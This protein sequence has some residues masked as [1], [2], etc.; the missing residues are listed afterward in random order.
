MLYYAYVANSVMLALL[1]VAVFQYLDAR[2]IQRK[3][4][5]FLAKQSAKTESDN[6]C[7]DHSD[8]MQNEP[9]LTATNSEKPAPTYIKNYSALLK[10]KNHQA[11]QYGQQHLFFALLNRSTSLKGVAPACGLLFTVISIMLSFGEF[12]S[13]GSVQKM[14]GIA[15]T[16]FSTTALGALVVVLCRLTIDRHIVPAMMMFD[17]Q[18]MRHRRQI[19]SSQIKS[20]QI[21]RRGQQRRRLIARS[22]QSPC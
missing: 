6:I 14:F 13:S 2:D 1:A 4:Y 22:G 21:R 15:A 5:K 8:A 9:A 16:G 18:L 3:L 19:K 11:I 12:A 17:K 7:D 10:A 20:S